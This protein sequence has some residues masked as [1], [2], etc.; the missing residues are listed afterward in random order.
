MAD[1]TVLYKGSTIAT[2]NG[3]GTKVLKTGGT[4]CEGDV[5]V[6]YTKPVNTGTAT[7]EDIAFGKTAWVNGEKLDGTMHRRVYE[8]KVTAMVVGTGT[9]ALLAKDPFL[10]EHRN[11]SN[12]FVRVAFDL[13]SIPYT[14]VK[15]WAINSASSLP[16]GGTNT[17]QWMYRYS[18]SGAQSMNTGTTPLN[19]AA[20]AG[21]GCVQITADG[22][23]RIYAN[24]DNYAIRPGGYTVVVEW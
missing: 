12:L 11:D 6:A 2:M 24:S 15:T 14:V 10:A 22:E 16:I 21:V 13:E 1:V 17:C 23:L 19:S 5:T 9:Y 4:Y 20:P 7:A 8:G 18:G 3:S